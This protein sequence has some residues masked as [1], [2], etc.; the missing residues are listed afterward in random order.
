[1]DFSAWS[2]R[3]AARQDGTQHCNACVLRA[4]ACT[5]DW[6]SADGGL[7]GRGR[8]PW[9]RTSGKEVSDSRAE[10]KWKGSVAATFVARLR[11]TRKR[12]EREPRRR[13][14]AETCMGRDC[15]EIR[16][17]NEGDTKEAQD[18]DA[19]DKRKR[20]RDRNDHRRDHRR[21][22]EAD[23]A[24]AHAQRRRKTPGR[25]GDKKRRKRRRPEKVAETKK[26]RQWT[27]H[28]RSRCANDGRNTKIR[29]TAPR[30]ER[31]ARNTDDKA[32]PIRVSLLQCKCQ[33]HR[34]HRQG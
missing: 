32:I 25:S 11:N 29:S 22:R 7:P 5:G 12:V 23:T 8:Q 33:Q 21:A 13:L 3:R 15:G 27:G 2:K 14:V 18:G 6:P 26:G 30:A 31:T 9:W 17:S 28:A 19:Q 24:G 10:G 1:M 4:A 20:R 16:T 34:S